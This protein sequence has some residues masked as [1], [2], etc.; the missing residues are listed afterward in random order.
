MR[1]IK[2]NIEIVVQLYVP[3]SILVVVFS[4]FQKKTTYCCRMRILSVRLSS[5]E[6]ISFLGI[7]MSNSP[8]YLKIALNVSEGAVDVRKA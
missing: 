8:I 1:T 6:I 7:S 4:F 2:Y 3:Y 5:V